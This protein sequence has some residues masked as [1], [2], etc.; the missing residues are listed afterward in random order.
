[1]TIAKQIGM[2]LMTAGCIGLLYNGL[3]F[4]KDPSNIKIGPIVLKVEEKKSVDFPLIM[5]AGAIA[6]GVFMVMAS[7]RR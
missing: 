1:M 6:V 5:S 3:G 4:S 7:Q 2:I